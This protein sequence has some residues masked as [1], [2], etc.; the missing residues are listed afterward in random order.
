MNNPV[1]S[2]A[3]IRHVVASAGDKSL[4][5]A[6][7]GRTAGLLEQFA[8][9]RSLTLDAMGSVVPVAT[10]VALALNRADPEVHLTAFDTDGSL[11]LETG[12]LAGLAV[13]R[14]RI[15]Q[16]DLIVLDNGLYESAGSMRSRHFALD[17][18]SLFHA[19]SLEVV[20]IETAA[21]LAAFCAVSKGEGVRAAVIN[22]ENSG[23]VPSAV[24]VYDGREKVSR[25]L[26]TFSTMTSRPRWRRAEKL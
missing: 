8:G 20:L 14:H 12:C 26:D 7:L 5:I 13:A 11:L 16:L 18:R 24:S 19:F 15:R 2:E 25:F 21:D 10:G 6:G 17:W 1:S 3:V 22:V 23:A 4:F 9:Q